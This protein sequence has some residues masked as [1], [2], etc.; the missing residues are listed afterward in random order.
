M[1]NKN[2]NII[3]K[4]EAP[5]WDAIV[6]TFTKIYPNQKEPL[7][8]APMVSWRLGGEDPLD[9]I[10][11]YDGGE[12]FHFVTFGFSELYEKESEDYDYSGYGFEL[13]LKLKKSSLNN[14][15][16]EIECICGILQSLAKIS[17]EDGSIFQPYEYIYT[18][19]KNGMDSRSKSNI[20]GFVTALDRAG[21][22]STPNGKLQ[23]VELIGVTDRELNQVI[24]EKISVEELLKKLGNTLTDY[25]RKSLY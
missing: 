25:K 8:Y 22:I 6:E 12:Y 24:D 3:E 2:S 21:E 17:Y 11:V 18:G 15:D 20:T 5:G 10:S 13:T 19:Q 1:K 23:F 16:E 9:G 7:H 4:I 14:K